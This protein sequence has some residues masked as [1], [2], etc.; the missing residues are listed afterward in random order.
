[1]SNDKSKLYESVRPQIQGQNNNIKPIGF[2]SLV[3][4]INNLMFCIII[5]L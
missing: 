2:D 5:Y 4:S 1:M 3:N